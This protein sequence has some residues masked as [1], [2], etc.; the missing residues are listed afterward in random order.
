MNITKQ[1]KRHQRPTDHGRALMVKLRGEIRRLFKKGTAFRNRT[2]PEP[3]GKTLVFR[4]FQPYG[5]SST[6]K[7]QDRLTDSPLSRVN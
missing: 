1:R 6:E 2:I 4:R 7:Q 5:W 3:T